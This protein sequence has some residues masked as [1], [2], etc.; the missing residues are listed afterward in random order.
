MLM[1][2]IKYTEESLYEGDRGRDTERKGG[3]RREGK[4]VWG[5]RVAEVMPVSRPKEDGV[6]CT[7]SGAGLRQEHGEFTSSYRRKS[8]HRWAYGVRELVKD[9]FCLFLFSQ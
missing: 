1:G 9:M 7:H 3:R 6:V 8:T 2:K 5:R 4:G